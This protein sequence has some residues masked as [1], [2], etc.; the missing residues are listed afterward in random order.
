M[1]G[2]DKNWLMLKMDP[3]K[4]SYEELEAKVKQLWNLNKIIV[5][6]ANNTLHSVISQLGHLTNILENLRDFQC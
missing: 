6:T 2:N 5:D 4:P 3:K 1:H